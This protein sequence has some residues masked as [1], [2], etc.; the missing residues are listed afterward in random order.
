MAASR[1]H[2]GYIYRSH[3][4]PTDGDEP[5]SVALAYAIV[6]GCENHDTN[7]E[8]MCDPSNPK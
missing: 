6:N 8:T 2:L 7:H 4:G 5:N 3:L 1:S